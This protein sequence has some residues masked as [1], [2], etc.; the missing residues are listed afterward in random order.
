MDERRLEEAWDVDEPP[1]GFAE[2]VVQTAVHKP[3]P[4]RSSKKPIAFA[5][6]AV[7]AAVLVWFGISRAPSTGEATASTRTEVAIGKRAMA[8]LEPGA[9][10]KWNG[11]RVTQETGD[12]F[13]RVERGGPFSV[14]TPAGMVEVLGTCFR[15]RVRP[16]NKGDG[17]VKS[18]KEV[19]L[20]AGSAAIAA[21]AVVTVYEGKVRLSHAKGKVDL[22]AG[23]SGA[24]DENGAR[25]ADGEALSSAEAAVGEKGS[26]LAKANDEL[27]KDIADLNRRI[28]GAEQ[29]KAKL[30]GELLAAQTELAKRTDGG[31]PRGRHEFDLDE[32]DWKALAEEG[33]V[34]FRVPCLRST[35]W[36]ADGDLLD[37]LGLSADD[38]STLSDA[39]KRSNDRMWGV[40]RPLC[41]K[42]IG[43][44]DVVDSLGPDT[45]THVVVDMARKQNSEAAS[46]AM[47]L[48]A[49]ARAGLKPAPA[50]GQQGAVFE[51][52]W[53]LTG[54]MSRF[55]G[56]L[57]QSFGPEEAKR[58]AYAEGMCMGHSTFGGPGPRKK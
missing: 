24:L 34:K 45:C 48:V 46:E 3:A 58:I 31:A 12:V 21:L 32:T 55:E 10:V 27:A 2:R 57:A 51:T 23:E 53:A 37:K 42:A 1:A 36:K 18:K 15:V 49:E 56:D 5:A 22:A 39:Y 40:I 20:A 47:R 8:V 25:R 19:A 14:E 54:E 38:A 6:L 50:A 41:V 30:E 28:K 33:T 13:Y 35:P 26:S 43:S 7:A 52:F 16:E 11:D 4:R 17:N 29:S 9:N 44:A